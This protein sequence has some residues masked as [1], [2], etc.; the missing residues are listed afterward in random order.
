MRVCRK[1]CLRRGSRVLTCSPAHHRVEIYTIPKKKKQALF[2]PF[3]RFRRFRRSHL[4]AQSNAVQRKTSTPSSPQGF[5]DSLTPSRDTPVG[6]VG[7]QDAQDEIHQDITATLDSIGPLLMQT[8]TEEEDETVAYIHFRKEYHSASIFPASDLL[9]GRRQAPTLFV[10][11]RPSPLLRRRPSRHYL[12]SHCPTDAS[13]PRCG[14]VE[15]DD[16]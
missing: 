16:D 11:F 5:A 13:V 6:P 15:A 4:D 12:Q 3:H 1:H 14:D 9:I 10:C 7:S 8:D 2:R